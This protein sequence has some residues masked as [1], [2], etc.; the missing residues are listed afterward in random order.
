VRSL[1]EPGS[2]GWNEFVRYEASRSRILKEA[3]QVADQEAYTPLAFAPRNLTK[4]LNEPSNSTPMRIEHVMPDGGRV[5]FS[6][7]QKAG[8]TT[9][10]ANLIRSLVD[11]TAFLDAFGVFKK[12]ERL[13]LID[14]ELSEDMVRAWLQTQGIVNTDAVA[15]V[16]CLR[17]R[18]SDFDIVNDKRRGEWASHLRDLE[19]DYLIFDCLRPVL[20]AL[21]LDE[22]HHAGKFLTAFDALLYEAEMP[23]DSTIVHHMGHSNER[24][25]G[26]SRIQDWPD[27][28][29]KIVREDEND[30]LSQRFFSAHGRDVEVIEGKL[31]FD[32][33]TRHLSYLGSTRSDLKKQ[34][35]YAPAITEAV[36]LLKNDK[37]QGN[38]GIAKTALVNQIH[39]NIGVSLDFSRNSG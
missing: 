37:V 17:G 31:R 12:A 15:D 38:D 20:D 35:R 19:C 16:M 1:P 22:W 2:N 24:A 33:M 9:A 11:G 30:P 23:G 14:D 32:D 8:K 36:D 7:P 3:R 4:F 10:I 13:V 27:A 6:A 39:A 25:R 18:V 29:W 28:I 5:V 26:D 34:K 21:G